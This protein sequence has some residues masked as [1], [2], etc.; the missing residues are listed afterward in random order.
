[1]F[2]HYGDHEDFV[3]AYQKWVV[4][5]SCGPFINIYNILPLIKY[6]G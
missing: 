4:E 6:N 1:M 3:N 5:N 2:V